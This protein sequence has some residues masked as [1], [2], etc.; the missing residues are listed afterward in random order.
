MSRLSLPGCLCTP[1]VY[2]HATGLADY[3]RPCWAPSRRGYQSQHAIFP[4][5]PWDLWAGEGDTWDPNSWEAPPQRKLPL[6]GARGPR[7]FR[8]L[9]EK[10]LLGF[11]QIDPE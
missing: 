9:F 6:G 7:V 10:A 3:W 11:R 5:T 1:I 2:L 4:E 8:A